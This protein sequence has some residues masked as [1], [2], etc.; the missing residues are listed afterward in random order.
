MGSA[1][2]THSYCT[3]ISAFMR[4]MLDIR[5]STIDSCSATRKWSVYHDCNNCTYEI[6]SHFI[7]YIVA[8]VTKGDIPLGSNCFL[9]PG[10]ELN[11]YCLQSSIYGS[12]NIIRHCVCVCVCVSVSECFHHVCV[13]TCKSM[14][15]CVCMGM[16]V[17][18]CTCMRVCA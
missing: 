5:L 11:T 9:F 18:A 7:M 10:R 4:S 6:S 3:H 12:W 14:Y 15:V 2:S 13:C 8:M 16:C 1:A 17:C